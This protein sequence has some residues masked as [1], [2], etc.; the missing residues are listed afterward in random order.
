MKVDTEKIKAQGVKSLRVL[1]DAAKDVLAAEQV[2]REN[3]SEQ[4][5]KPTILRG[6]HHAS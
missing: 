5:Q 6:G 1:L 3:P 4:S 2:L